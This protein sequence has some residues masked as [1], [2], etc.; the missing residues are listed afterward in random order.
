[1]RARDGKMSEGR[2]KQRAQERLVKGQTDRACHKS[3]QLG[4]TACRC[5][6]G[7]KEEEINM[8]SG[9]TA[10]LWKSNTKAVPKCLPYSA[11]NS[12]EIIWKNPV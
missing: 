7:A 10:G 12:R 8:A 4:L 3:I 5:S 11:V 1:M 9:T 2:E 6:C